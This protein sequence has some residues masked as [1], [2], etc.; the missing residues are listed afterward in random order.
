MKEKILKKLKSDTTSFFSGEELSEK[1]GV[2]RTAVWKSINQLKELGYVIESQTKKGYRLIASPDTLTPIEIDFLLN[3]EVIGRQVIY[4]DSI[5]STNNQAKRLAEG[6]FK[7]GTVVIA[8]EQ[9]SGRGRCG[10]DWISPKGKGIWMSII[11][12]PH[13]SPSDAAK[14]TI[15][16]ACA[17]CEGIEA[18]CNIETKIKWPNDIIVNG[19]KIC[20]I[21]TELGAEMDSVNY[22]VVGIGINA[23]AE[24]ADFPEEIKETATSIRL[25]TGQVIPRKQIAAQVLNAFDRLYKNFAVDGSIQNIIEIYKSKSAVLG[26]EIRVISKSGESMGK[27]CDITEEGHL[28]ICRPDGSKTEVISGEVSVRGMHGYI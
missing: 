14:I 22:L 12:K 25:E 18:V 26:K 27:A 16:A 20:G 6:D 17:V 2:S 15:L 13:I 9:T 1:L 24:A 28:V 21:L 7:D 23:R 5:D 8:E 19:K 11:L 10:K 3:T 4:Y